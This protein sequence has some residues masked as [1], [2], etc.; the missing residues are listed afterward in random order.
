MCGCS[1]NDNTHKYTLPPPLLLQLQLQEVYPWVEVMAEVLESGR[2][3]DG[4][5]VETLSSD[6]FN[7]SR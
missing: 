6:L 3:P 5:P 1:D 2:S 4:T 7:R